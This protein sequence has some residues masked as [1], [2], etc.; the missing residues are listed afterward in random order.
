MQLKT[1]TSIALK[2]SAYVMLLLVLFGIGINLGSFTQRYRVESNRVEM[3]IKKVP[4]Q[5]KFLPQPK[6]ELIII[7][8][9][10]D[11]EQELIE[12]RVWR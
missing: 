3:G 10:D 8:Y 9:S 7:P 12:H 4:R 11:A 2:F 5:G 6:E 1:S